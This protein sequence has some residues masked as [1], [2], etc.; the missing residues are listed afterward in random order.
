MRIACLLGTWSRIPLCFVMYQLIALVS[1][2]LTKTEVPEYL[3][4]NFVM[5]V[6]N[7]T[8]TRAPRIETMLR[9]FDLDPTL[10]A[11]TGTGAETGLDKGVDSKPNKGLELD[12]TARLRLCAVAQVCFV[13][14][15]DS[16]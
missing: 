6:V 14:T 4:S 9:R 11:G 3:L 8:Q 10:D 5:S 7:W 12:S 15:L 1:I 13:L 16:I 2:L